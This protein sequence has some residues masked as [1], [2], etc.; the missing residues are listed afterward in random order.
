MADTMRPNILFIC[1]DQW[2]A[3]CLSATGHPTVETPHLDLIADQGVIFTQAY[4][5]RIVQP[6]N[7]FP[8]I[9]LTNL[10]DAK[11]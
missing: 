11:P 2:R 5:P 10:N 9:H 3:D 6:T 7:L 8:V 4:D 1:V